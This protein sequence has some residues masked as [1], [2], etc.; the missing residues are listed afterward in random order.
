M[1]PNHFKQKLAEGKVPVG[2]MLLE[3]GARSIARMLQNAGVD[4]VLIDNEHSAFT[5]AEVADLIAWFRATEI[6][7]FVRV[8]EIQYHLIARTLDLGAQGVMIPNVKTAAEAKAVVDAAKYAPLGKRGVI[9]GQANTDFQTLAPADFLVEANRSTTIICQIESVEGVE[10]VEAIAATPGIDVLWVGHFDLTQSQGIPGQF[11]NPIFL[12]AMEKIVAAARRHN[13]GAGIQPGSL[14]QAE[15]WMK[16]GFNV[17][18]YSADFA[19][20]TAALAAGVDAVQKLAARI[21]A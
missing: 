20:Y 4:F 8:P 19:V 1:K 2:H 6:A 9:M 12:Q 10:N 14:A 7:P 3:F 17:I 11:H 18:S 13:L 16:M 5:T 21:T 15:E